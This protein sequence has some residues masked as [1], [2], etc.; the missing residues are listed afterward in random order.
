M[1][2]RYQEEQ[3]RFRCAGSE[4]GWIQDPNGIISRGHSTYSQDLM[5]WTGKKRRMKK[6]DNI[7]PLPTNAG[8]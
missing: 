2:K 6:P 3:I 8:S 4:F 7:C 1:G 5:Q